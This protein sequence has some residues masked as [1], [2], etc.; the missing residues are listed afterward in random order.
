MTL[1]CSCSITPSS[2]LII[3]HCCFINC[4]VLEYELHGFICAYEKM[5]EVS[6][7]PLVHHDID[8]WLKHVAFMKCYENGLIIMALSWSY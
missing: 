4:F 7:F 2:P 6:F 8:A 3:M 1:P 5:D